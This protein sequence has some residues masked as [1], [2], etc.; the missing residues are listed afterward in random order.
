MQVKDVMTR[1]VEVI[2]PDTTLDEAAQRMRA[3]AVGMLPVQDGDEVVGVVTDRDMTVRAIARGLDPQTATAG[4]VMTPDVVHCYEDQTVEAAAEQMAAN[5]VRR[6]VVLDRAQQLVGV[7]SLDDL[8]RADGHSGLAGQVLGYSSAPFRA[9]QGRF[10]RILVSLDGSPFAERILETVAPLAL[11]LG[12]TVT[13]LRAVAPVPTYAGTGDGDS[14]PPSVEDA[15]SRAS[16]Y[17]SS[18]RSRL[19]DEGLT[20]EQESLDGPASE[21]ILRRARQLDVDLIALT[22]HGRIGMD[23][24]LL[25]SVAEDVLRRASCPVLLVRAASGHR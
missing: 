7:I 21:V 20:V 17:L 12:A 11:K 22:T 24:V 19:E 10:E 2:S 4:E 8:A 9:R 5:R 1:E 13:L 15:R 6:L 3:V 14:V 23:R 25:G 18:V 16:A